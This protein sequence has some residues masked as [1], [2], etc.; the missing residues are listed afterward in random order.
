MKKN[1]KRLEKGIVG[2]LSVLLV[3]ELIGAGVYMDA[4]ADNEVVDTAVSTTEDNISV[5][6]LKAEAKDVLQN[7]LPSNTSGDPAKDETVYVL[8]DANGTVDHVIVSDW[9]Q[10]PQYADSMHDVSYLNE[11]ENVKDE[12]SYEVDGTSYEWDTE[13]SD[14]YYQGTT[15]AELP[16]D[17]AVT[18]Y[19][20]GE[21]IRADELAGKTGTVTMRFDY[22]NHLSQTV[23]IDG[24]NE[25]IYTPLTVITSMILDNDIFSDVTVTNGKVI[26]DGSR[27][28]VV[29]IAMPGL[30]DSL[31][32]D[33]EDYEI[34]SYVEVTANAEDFSLLATMTL[35]TTELFN[36]MDFSN[37]T[38]LSDLQDA[39][40]Q[41]DEAGAALADGTSQL[42][43]GLSTLLTKSE[44]LVTGIN[45]I[46]DAGEQ[47]AEASQTIATNVTTINSAAATLSGGLNRLSASN[48]TL[49]NG[50]KSVFTTL[51]NS[52]SNQLTSAGLT[53]QGGMTMDCYGTVLDNTIAYYQNAAVREGM[54]VS[55]YN[56]SALVTTY[57]LPTATTQAEAQG[58]VDASGNQAIQDAFLSIINGVDNTI[59]TTIVPALSGAKTSLDSYN[60]FYQGLKTYTEGV[61]S[62]AG[63][64][65]QL[66]SGIDKLNV[67]TTEFATKL[68][69]F[70]EGL[71][72]LKSGSAAL[73]SGVTQLRDASEEIA[74][75]MQE[76]Y[77]EGISKLV[78]SID[79][80]KLN[81]TIRRM[82]EVGEAGSE[83][84]NFSGLADSMNGSV[85][86]IYKTDSIE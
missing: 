27:S 76:Y 59:N 23:D 38:T 49:M 30:Q 77:E 35:A 50:A 63:G 84:N 66:A 10:N 18:Y 78:N 4:H 75:G 43:D 72:T 31:A 51:V 60:S 29:G 28:I 41:L 2:V 61:A 8:T 11:I 44:E 55:T 3:G 62:A 25:T 39:M 58:Y 20:N 82:Q 74:D 53:L 54:I 45:T 52:A 48:D 19:L 70:N 42:Y 37:I 83:Y 9:L 24:N 46:A 16:L 36:G 26:N 80:D 34:P 56:S 15:D 22:T 81:A 85:K 32:I 13:G 67:G 57:N 5:D 14:L 65:V 47:L 12:R 68:T 69:E 86:F 17:V 71:L 33:T 21:L 6:D 1:K 40:D 73:V 7:F 79:L 64:C